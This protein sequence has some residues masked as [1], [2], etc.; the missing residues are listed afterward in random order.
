VKTQIRFWMGGDGAY[1]SRSP[2]RR[3][4][5]GLKHVRVVAGRL[6]SWGHR[7]SI[8]VVS[9]SVPPYLLCFFNFGR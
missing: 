3:R 4:L 6:S 8:G 2:W 1:T 5:G 7:L 9:H